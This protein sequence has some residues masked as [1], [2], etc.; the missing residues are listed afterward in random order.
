MSRITEGA[1][2]CDLDLF[3]TVELLPS[4]SSDRSLKSD[5]S[6]MR[7]TRT[8]QIERPRRI[9][10]FTLNY[11]EWRQFYDAKTAKVADNWSNQL[12]TYISRIGIT[13]S[14]AFKKHHDKKKESR[15]KNCNL[16]CCRGRCMIKLCPVELCIIVEEKPRNKTS[17]SV[18]TVYVFGDADHNRKIATAR[19]PL[20]GLERSAMGMYFVFHK[21]H[22][23]LLFFVA[24]QVHEKGPLAVYERNLRQADEN[25]LQ[26]GNL[27][28]VPS[29]DVLKTAVYEYNNTYRLDEDIF[30][31]VRIFRELTHQWDETSEEIKGVYCV[32]DH[33]SMIFYE[34]ID[35]TLFGKKI[36]L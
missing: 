34:I 26:D 17:P 36:F 35:L 14:I 20:R 18:F 24:Q 31:E 7:T 22:L 2:Y 30:K 11:D 21:H 25:L 27:T 12:A 33:T 4:M 9:Q 13:C 15:K 23:T 19:R 5:C 10:H 32:E 3:Q 6:E 1:Y 8:K 29:T 16:F 28:Q